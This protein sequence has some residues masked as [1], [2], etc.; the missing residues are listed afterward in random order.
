MEM[1]ISPEIIEV[2]RFVLKIIGMI[3]AFIYILITNHNYRKEHKESSKYISFY[4]I[5][6][7]FFPGLSIFNQIFPEA[8]N[9]FI[10][11]ELFF[12]I[13]GN[14][15]L[16][17]FSWHL[18]Y[19]ENYLDSIYIKSFI[20]IYI[21]LGF[22]GSFIISAI[23]YAVNAKILESK[24]FGYVGIFILYILHFLSYIYLFFNMLFTAKQIKLIGNIEYSDTEIK[25][26]IK[27]A[28]IL[29]SG[30]VF[31]LIMLIFMVLDVLVVEHRT[32]F[33]PISWISYI[34]VISIFF[35]GFKPMKRVNE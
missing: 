10:G 4:F 18:F 12:S 8:N 17:F 2:S 26:F 19:R 35:S 6:Y 11:A 29:A 33:N 24:S 25:V 14:I 3:V 15:A 34:I 21:I 13:I 23:T 32:I 7:F 20:I 1:Q 5:F 22:I 28:Y 30:C 9:V 16:F 31:M 27:R